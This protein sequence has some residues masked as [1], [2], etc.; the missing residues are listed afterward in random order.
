MEYVPYAKMS[1]KQ[2]KEYNDSR[3]NTWSFSPIPRVKESRKVY[4]RKRLDR[5]I[6]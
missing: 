3:R 6:Y 4:N 2:K 5:A 1:K